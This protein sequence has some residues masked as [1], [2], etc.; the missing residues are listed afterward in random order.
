[1]MLKI[2]CQ[3]MKAPLS[4]QFKFHT[5]PAHRDDLVFYG[6]F[7][8][9]EPSSKHCELAMKDPKNVKVYP[10][11]ARIEFDNFSASQSHYYVTL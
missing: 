7:S 3:D 9:E 1:M 8:H 2:S 11:A 6:S 10:T 5:R 4:F